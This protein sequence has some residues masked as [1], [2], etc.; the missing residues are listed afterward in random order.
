MKTTLKS[1]AG[2]A[3]ICLAT[4]C[5]LASPALAQTASSPAK[6]ELI[7]KILLAQQPGIDQ[8]SRQIV[9]QPAIQLLQRAGGM[10]QSRVPAEQR[11][12]VAKELQADGRKFVEETYPIVRQRAMALAPSTVGAVLEEKLTEAEL[13]EV[14]GILESPAWRK[15]QGLTPDMQK[16]LGEKLVADVKPQVETRLKAMDQSMAKRLGITAPA[17]APSPAPAPAPGK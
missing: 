7:A 16:A 6:K 15:F 11:E 10:I 17:A 12:A 3:A 5:C 14:V 13:R 9:E 1:H 8:L 2:R 4:A